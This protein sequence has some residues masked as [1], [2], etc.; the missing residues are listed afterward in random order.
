MSKGEKSIT[1]RIGGTRGSKRRRIPKGVTHTRASL[2]NTII[3][4]ADARG[5]VVP[6]F[7]AGA[8]GFRGARKGTAFAA[9]TAAENAIRAL[10]DQGVKRA[11]VVITGPG[12]GRDT[13]LRAIRGGGV[14]LGCARDITPMPHNGC[15]PPK[16][17]CVQ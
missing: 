5:Q 6:R 14:V 12:P 13:A 7:P 8:S 1:K 15:R 3:T 2:N 4:V 16:K 11:E 9:Q 17:R 10:I